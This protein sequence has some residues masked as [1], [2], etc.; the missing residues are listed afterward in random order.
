MS[1]MENY[2]PM[3]KMIKIKH[4]NFWYVVSDEEFTKNWLPN[5][6]KSIK[7]AALKRG[8]YYGRWV[9][10]MERKGTGNHATNQNV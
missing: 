1:N 6:S 10:E 7:M 5:V 4:H 2:E 9:K 8:K 3:E